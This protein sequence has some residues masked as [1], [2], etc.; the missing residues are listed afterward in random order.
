M[1]SISIITKNNTHTVKDGVLNAKSDRLVPIR[2][3]DGRMILRYYFDFKIDIPSGA[4]G[5]VLPPNTASSTSLAQV[6]SF[7]L[8]PGLTEE[9]YIDYKLN[10]DA[11]PSVYEKE[12]FCASIVFL[13][14]LV[15]Y[16]GMSVKTVIKNEED[17]GD[18]NNPTDAPAGDTTTKAEKQADVN[19]VDSESYGET[20]SEDNNVTNISD[21]YDAEIPVTDDQQDPA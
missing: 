21:Q 5:L 13:P 1:K 20:V 9:P 15:E 4:I 3:L 8:M 6:G 12:D 18:Q 2:G 7:V 10:T 19:P 14:I 16:P 11:I 17:N